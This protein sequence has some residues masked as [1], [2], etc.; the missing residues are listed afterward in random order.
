MFVYYRV[1]QIFVPN[2]PNFVSFFMYIGIFDCC[3]FPSIKE[4][5]ADPNL[6]LYFACEDGD[7]QTVFFENFI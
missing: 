3:L 7:C 6:K 4:E 5:D 2:H 1:F